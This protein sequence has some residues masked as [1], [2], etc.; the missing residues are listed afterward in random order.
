MA[1]KNE[2][3]I[4]ITGDTT[5]LATAASK[6]DKSIDGL[7]KNTATGGKLIG[8]AMAGAGVAIAAFGMSAIKSYESAGK[9][10]MKLKRLTGEGAE[11]MS[12]LRVVAQQSGV[13]MDTL[14]KSITVFSKAT[15]GQT[16]ALEEMG[17][18]AKNADGSTRP[19]T[20]TLGDLAEQFAGSE[21][22][23]WKTRQAMK[24]FGKAGADMV[25]LLNKGKDGIAE[26]TEKAK[27]M[28]LVM[29]EEGLE[30]IKAQ[31]AAQRDLSAAVE[32]LKLQI[33]E[34]LVPV[35]ETSMGVLTKVVATWVEMPGPMKNVLICTAALAGA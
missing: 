2:V 31:V 6:A 22:N 35:M 20:A 9:E 19:F 18:S 10:T 13:G 12:A 17:V 25:P 16:K 8:G 3:K 27:K 5:G 30:K 11:A 26:L 23:A 1:G 21:D 24:L 28:G 32:G 4:R 7:G 29:G 14:T 34:Q 33:G 15:P